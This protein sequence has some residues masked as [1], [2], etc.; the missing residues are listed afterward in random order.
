MTRIWSSSA[1][2]SRPPALHAEEPRLH[3]AIRAPDR[4]SSWP[5]GTA[6]ARAPVATRRFRLRIVRVVR[7]LSPGRR[8]T[9]MNLAEAGVIAA[10]AGVIATEAEVVATEAEV[11]ATDTRM[12]ATETRTWVMTM[13][14]WTMLPCPP[15]PDGCAFSVL[16][17]VLHFPPALCK[18]FAGTTSCKTVRCRDMKFGRIRSLG[19]EPQQAPT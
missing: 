9:C 14:P 6:G 3:T 15:P 1:S 16:W 17:S 19:G 5:A 8:T 11:V 13:L 2:T 7:V 18:I 4:S 10:E 12:M